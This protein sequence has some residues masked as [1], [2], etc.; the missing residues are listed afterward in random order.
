MN[1]WIDCWSGNG[2]LGELE[3]VEWTQNSLMLVYSLYWFSFKSLFNALF[4]KSNN[5]RCESIEWILKSW[6]LWLKTVIE[7]WRLESVNDQYK[8]KW[9]KIK[10][11]EEF[12]CP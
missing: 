7:D 12:N 4:N 2:Y 6:R 5:N 8:K 1:C 9:I 10:K 3:D 11:Y